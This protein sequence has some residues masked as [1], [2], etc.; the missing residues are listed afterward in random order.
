MNVDEAWRNESSPGV[1]GFRA[2]RQ[3]AARTH[4]IDPAVSR[5]DHSIRNRAA[6][7]DDCAIEE[8][9]E[10]HVRL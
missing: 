2:G 9:L 1:D 7:R 10:S 6:I 3:F 4:V 5:Y 8:N